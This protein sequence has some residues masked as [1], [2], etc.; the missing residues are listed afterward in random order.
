MHTQLSNQIPRCQN[1]G[2]EGGA[3]DP[4]AGAGLETDMQAVIRAVA[5]AAIA[6]WGGA[7]FAQDE[8]PAADPPADAP[9]PAAAEEPTEL[10]TVTVTAQKRVQRLTDVPINVSAINGDDARNARIEQV[11]DLA[12]LVSNVDIKEQVPG[13]IPVVTIRGVGLDDFS[14]TNSPAAGI[15]VDQVT[16][17]SLAL[18]SF[19]LFDVQRIEVLKGP[20]GTLYGRNSTAGAINVLSAAPAWDNQGYAR[21]GYGAYQA[22]DI[23]AMYNAPLGDTFALRVAGKLIRQDQGLWD[24]RL[25]EGDAYAGPGAYSTGDPV[26]RDIGLRDVL[27]GRARLAWRPSDALDV[28]LKVESLRQRSEMGQ[29]EMFGT[30]PRP[31]GSGTCAPVD[32]DNCAD[33]TAYSDDDGDPYTGHYRGEFPYDIDQQSRTLTA[34]WDLGWG[35]VSSVTG[36]MEFERFFHIDT[37]GTPG[38]Q[39]NFLQADTVD[40]VTQELRLAGS[41]GLGDWLVGAFYGEDAITIDTEGRHGDNP[42]LAFFGVNSSVITADQDTES[43]A[44][45]ANMDWKLA[46]FAPGLEA[47]TVTTGLRYTDETRDYVGGTTWNAT[48]PG[49]IDNTSE[50]SSISDDNWSWKAGLNYKPAPAQLLYANVSS[51][52]KSGGYFAGVTNAQYQLDP[53]LPEQLTAYEVGYK[54]SGPLAINASVFRYDYKD[55]QTFMRTGG[56]AAQFIGN[57]PEA[58]VTGLDVEATWRAL[59]GLALTGGVGLLD[60]SLGAFIG[61]AD[62]DGDGQGDPVPAGNELPNSPGL[63]WMARVRYELPSF[64]SLVSAL[65]ADAHYADATYK[66]ATNDPFIRSGD[67][68]LVNA[69]FSLLPA[70]RTWEFALWGRN[71]TD[72]LYVSQGLDLATFGLG[73]RNYNAPRTFG[74]ELSWNF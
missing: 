4:A 26:V 12:S 5:F 42:L 10:D 17:S 37:D 3:R 1:N 68:T 70:E 29:P 53:Y 33:M 8:T 39:F 58:E 28:D 21:F 71:L 16:L 74:A 55:K 60:T 41:A 43:A 11:R 52:V 66:E 57:V 62:A 59:E 35:T 63:T 32:A 9:A 49:L 20:Q 7:G 14:S 45:F 18:M 73:N 54:L 22:A 2:N 46:A 19:D 38:D 51:G 31:S 44:L 65:Q 48:V 23:E 69:R 25:E 15:Y 72:E 47:F 56:A 27:A 34:D 36:A 30:M 64:G 40:Q 13:A 24:S 61:P 50:D 6:A 67:Y